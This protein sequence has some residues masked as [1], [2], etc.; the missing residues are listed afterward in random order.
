M[1]VSSRH[2]TNLRDIIHVNAENFPDCVRPFQK[3]IASRI[4]ARTAGV[5]LFESDPEASQIEQ[6]S[7]LGCGNLTNANFRLVP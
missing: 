7:K 4:G 1:L 5:L 2:H 6:N 3:T